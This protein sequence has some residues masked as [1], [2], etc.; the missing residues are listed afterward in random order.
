MAIWEQG[1]PKI[2]EGKILLQKHL[3]DRAQICVGHFRTLRYM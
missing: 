2:L 3:L 1:D